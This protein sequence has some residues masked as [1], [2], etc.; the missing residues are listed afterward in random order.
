MLTT[1]VAGLGPGLLA[2]ALSIA[3]AKHFFVPVAGSFAFGSAGDVF[4]FIWLGRQLL[5]RGHRV[6]MITACLFEEQA[7]KAGLNFIPFGKKDEFEAMMHD[8]RIW[9]PVV[10][11]KLVFECAAGYVE[12]LP[13]K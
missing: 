3:A 10:G 11:T 13:A 5:A 8:P 2:A 6:T 9:K 4:P 7:K 1:L 12:S